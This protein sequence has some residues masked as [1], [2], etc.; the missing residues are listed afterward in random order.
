[1]K[2]KLPIITKKV[3]FS[4]LF[5][6]ISTIIITA[7]AFVFYLP[8]HLNEIKEK[9]VVSL[10]EKISYTVQIDDLSAEWNGINPSLILD[11]IAVFNKDQV[12]SI[13]TKKI[14]VDFSWLSLFKLRPVIDQI[15]LLEPDV[16][17]VKEPDGT[18]SVNGITTNQKSVDDDL[19]NWALNLDDL[20]ISNGTLSWIDKTINASDVILFNNVNFHYGSSKALA[21]LGRRTFEL[22]S[23]MPKFSKNPIRLSGFFN[24]LN[25]SDRDDLDGAASI[26]LQKFSL[27]LIQPWQKTISQIEQGEVSADLSVGFD[28]GNINDVSGLL[29]ID[30]LRATTLAKQPINFDSLQGTIDFKRNENILSFKLSDLSL[31]QNAEFKVN[32]ASLRLVMSDQMEVQSVSL[33][34]ARINLEDI[35]KAAEYLPEPFS[36]AKATVSELGLKGRISDVKLSWDNNLV[37]LQ[38]LDLSLK[39]FN[40]SSNAFSEMPSFENLTANI[41]LNKGKG[42]V[43]LLSKN[44]IVRKNSLFR[45]ALQFDQFSGKLAWDKDTYKFSDVVLKNKDF[46]SKVNGN[47]VFGKNGGYANLNV[48]VPFANIS[49]LK[50]Y[51]PKNIS[52]E[53]LSWL[54]T[55]L[56]SGQARNINLALKG[57]LNEFPYVDEENKPDYAKGIFKISSSFHAT[58]IE[59]SDDWPAIVNFDF[60]L[61]TDNNRVD[62]ISNSGEIQ[63]NPIQSLRA[64]IDAFNTNN[65]V[66]KIDA[67]LDSPIPKI[68]SL[69]NNSPI[70]AKLDGITE[71]MTGDGPGALSFQVHV[72][73]TNLDHILFNGHYD[74]IGSSI[75]NKNLDL[76]RLGDIKARFDFDNENTKIE[77]GTASI[78]GQPFELSMNN[79]NAETI[80]KVKGNIDTKNLEAMNQEISSRI[81]GL[82]QWEGEI[83]LLND[84]VDLN[85]HADLKDM[86]IIKFGPF[87]KSN[88]QSMT[89]NLNKSTLGGREDL[90]TFNVK[91]LVNARI[92]Q[93]ENNSIKHGFIAINTDKDVMPSKG[94]SLYG[95]FNDINLDD[96]SFLSEIN[97]DAEQNTPPL[98]NFAEL[99]FNSLSIPNALDLHEVKI[100]LKNNPKGFN[101]KLSAKETDGTVQWH[102]NKNLYQVMLNKLE[103]S[104]GDMGYKYNGVDADSYDEETISD[105]LAINIEMQIDSLTI[106]NNLYGAIELMASEI[107]SGWDFNS[108]KIKKASN[109]IEGNGKWVFKGKPSKSTV[110]FQWELNDVERTLNEMNFKN[111]ISKGYARLAGALSWE[112]NPLNF[113]KNILM[114]SFSLYAKDGAVLEINRGVSGRLIGLLSLQNLPQRLTLDFSDLFEKGMPFT[115]IESKNILLNK[116]RLSSNAFGIKGPSADI[117]L[118]GEVHFI[119]ETQNLHI[120]VKPKISDTL[121]LGALAGGPLAAAAAFIA[122]KI[123]DD[124]LNKI[125]SSEYFITGTWDDPEEQKVNN[126]YES[127]VDGVIIKPA[128]NLYNTIAEP[129]EKVLKNIVVDP[130]NKL[131]GQEKNNE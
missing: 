82:A 109:T 90:F 8:S 104:G 69:V 62:I 65:P 95:N 53:G 40:V 79:V 30:A 91:N 70:K 18:F 83:K 117:K 112:G 29:K 105:S 71:K 14:I 33:N 44:L 130:L 122:Q 121:T 60:E 6:V 49:Q 32:K 17:L 27:K 1:M 10:S 28:A 47:Y 78:Y 81:Q 55:S 87:N 26:Y 103:V 37:F 120:F 92:V 12:K 107:D 129:T 43:Q 50:P 15:T 52:K 57:N 94:L 124:P 46:E 131:F 19:A 88:G 2:N 9:I 31:K 36:E 34:S 118:S 11:N 80:F 39:A 76:P 89:I 54:D 61:S 51:Y 96:F 86:A 22:T 68:L 127:M 102:K 56:L 126:N 63:S 116:G 7:L 13:S 108:F 41:E 42:F 106:D 113:N 59:Y 74:F 5:I 67:M 38:D 66:I 25:Y 58:K 123:L 3:V 73:M 99:S 21:F 20:I 110:N 45:E 119:N 24:L 98:I 125:T 114:G 84:G 75:E 97:K 16:L 100:T 35:S 101:L 115:E 128:S 85:L 77:K 111:L 4:S 64:S 93:N 23:S 48:N 72:P